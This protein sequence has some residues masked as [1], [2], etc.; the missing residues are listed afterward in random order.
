MGAKFI[1]Y[2]IQNR[3]LL[4]NL[5]FKNTLKFFVNLFKKKCSPLFCIPL[6]FLNK[7]LMS[8]PLFSTIIREEV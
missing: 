5:N 1:A 4:K 2:T 6:I 7:T 3:F 8:D